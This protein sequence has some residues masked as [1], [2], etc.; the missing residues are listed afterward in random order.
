M[1]WHKQSRPCRQCSN[2]E[3]QQLYN[4]T[5]LTTWVHRGS[6]SKRRELAL[7][8]LSTPFFFSP[9]LGQRSLKLRVSFPCSCSPPVCIICSVISLSLAATT[10]TPEHPFF[11][12]H[13][14]PNTSSDTTCVL[15]RG[16]FPTAI[17]L[18]PFCMCGLPL[19]T[20]SFVNGNCSVL[21][22]LT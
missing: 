18:T 15:G 20:L 7:S 11:S 8:S 9:I 22:A 1:R 5:S 3:D 10:R 21:P 14:Y 4:R 19:K 13:C 6:L 2:E 12:T 17:L 16:S